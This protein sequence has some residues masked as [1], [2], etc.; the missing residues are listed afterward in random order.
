MGRFLEPDNGRADIKVPA[1]GWASALHD[2]PCVIALVVGTAT[3]DDETVAEGEARGT[4]KARAQ[5]PSIG[6]LTNVFTLS[7]MS[8][9]SRLTWLLEMPL[10]PTAQTGSR[11]RRRKTCVRISSPCRPAVTRLR[12]AR[13]CAAQ[14]SRPSYFVS[15]RSVHVPPSL[16][17]PDP[18]GNLA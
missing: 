8:L 5:S 13:L 10:I 12:R 4:R 17:Q 15:L 2:P 3:T 16:D 9:Q 18:F 1:Y 7:S 14:L 6:R 11:S